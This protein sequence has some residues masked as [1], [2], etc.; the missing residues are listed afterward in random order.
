MWTRAYLDAMAQL[1]KPLRQAEALLEIGRYEQATAL[2]AGYLAGYPD[3]VAGLTLMAICRGLAGDT[4]ATAQLARQAM[5]LAPDDPWPRS[6]Y[7]RALL[8]QD[9]YRQA[10]RETELLL[11]LAFEDW[12]THYLAAVAWSLG[13]RPNL[14]AALE[15]AD[16]ACGL[17]PEEPDVHALRGAILDRLG[18]NRAAKQAW[19]RALGLDPGH[20]ATQTQLSLSDLGA[21]RVLAG[22]RGLTES[23]RATP[24]DERAAANLREAV[25]SLAIRLAEW[26]S[27]G[28]AAQLVVFLVADGA[29]AATGWVPAVLGAL[30]LIL[31]AVVVTGMW[32]GTPGVALRLALLRPENRQRWQQRNRLVYF[33]LIG[34]VAIVACTAIFA[35]AAVPL[36]NDNAPVALVAPFLVCF[37]L[38]LP[39]SF[40]A[41]LRL[42][43]RLIRL[44]VYRLRGLRLR[45]SR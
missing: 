26:T 42:V 28:L 32:R 5:A 23:V 21:G 36:Q 13:W 40:V 37:L 39:L 31:D 11:S 44:T 35:F 17:A 20:A 12:R 4:R 41:A 22:V 7:V 45:G 10:R 14:R 2:V 8:A 24:A 1:D 34:N 18:D 19:Q 15:S 25:E 9:R 38:A 27:V 33:G 43:V 3:S 30:G 6:V 16:R 29:L